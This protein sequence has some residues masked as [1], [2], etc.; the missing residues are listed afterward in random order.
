MEQS[1]DRELEGPITDIQQLKVE[2]ERTKTGLE[3]QLAEMARVMRSGFEH[4]GVG[5][6][7]RVNAGGVNFTFDYSLLSRCIPA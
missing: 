7:H 4:V 6:P 3:E 1:V 5:L 2:L